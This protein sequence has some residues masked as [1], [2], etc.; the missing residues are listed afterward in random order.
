M[1]EITKP[2]GT[3]LLVPSVQELAK[4]KTSSVPQR[5]IQPQHDN[6]VIFSEANSILEIPIIDMQCLLSV[7]S[8][9]SELAKLHLACN[10]WGFFQL[11]NHGVS[12]FLV[13]KLKLEIQ[14]FSKLPMSE[15]K[16][17]WQS[18]Q[19]MEGFGQAFVVSD[20]QKLDWANMYSNS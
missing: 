15:K 20:D 7:E 4:E 18:P 3:S 9:S 12:S 13:E 8:G 10:E 1:A 6:V 2:F 5:Y 16:F 17:F 14:E 11:I 19:Y